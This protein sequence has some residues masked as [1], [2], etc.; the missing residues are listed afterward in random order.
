MK[1]LLLMPLMFLQTSCKS[2][3]IVS[4]PFEDYVLIVSLGD[5]NFFLFPISNYDDEF[6][7]EKNL[8]SINIKKGKLISN[9]TE[10]QYNTIFI[11]SKEYKRSDVPDD[12]D[13][14]VKYIKLMIH[15][16]K[17]RYLNEKN[18]QLYKRHKK[19]EHQ[20]IK[21]EHNITLNLRYDH[22]GVELL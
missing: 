8:K 4:N 7:L 14:S 13:D 17:Y 15:K 16:A 20:K 21:L 10:E 12:F 9:L 22:L 18:P 5:S 3:D 2:Q 19:L 6:S 1:L 11:N